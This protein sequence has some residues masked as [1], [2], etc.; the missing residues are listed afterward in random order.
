MKNKSEFLI[1]SKKHIYNQCFSEGDISEEESDSLLNDWWPIAEVAASYEAIKDNALFTYL[2]DKTYIFGLNDTPLNTGAVPI[3]PQIMNK[4][5]RLGI[6]IDNAYPSR[7]GVKLAENSGVT[8][9][10]SLVYRE[11]QTE[12]GKFL[13]MNKKILTSLNKASRESLVNCLLTRNLLSSLAIPLS[14][15]TYGI[16]TM[17]PTTG[18][19]FV[20]VYK[21]QEDIALL[22]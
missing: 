4:A 17:E 2:F 9:A 20:S 22:I 15:R 7:M 13:F 18:R 16:Y 8:V 14:I 11:K 19:L 10:L 5:K 21:T 3:N 1:N 6:T 12:L